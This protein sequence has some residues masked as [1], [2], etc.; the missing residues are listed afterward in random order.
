MLLQPHSPKGMIQVRGTCLPPRDTRLPS[1]SHISL[2]EYPLQEA[3]DGPRKL[4]LHLM[5]LIQINKKQQSSLPFTVL[6]PAKRLEPDPKATGK[7]FG[8]SQAQDVL[9]HTSVQI[10]INWGWSYRLSNQRWQDVEKQNKGA[11]TGALHFSSICSLVPPE[12]LEGSRPSAGESCV[13]P[14]S[15]VHS[16]PHVKQP[17]NNPSSLIAPRDWLVFGAQ[18]KIPKDEP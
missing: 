9:S 8:L 2:W 14:L 13:Y 7:G 17:C 16:S 18:L 10:L 6:S 4:W 12:H 5:N 3:S 15:L 11:S 1:R